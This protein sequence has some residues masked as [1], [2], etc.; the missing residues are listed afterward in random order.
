MNIFQYIFYHQNFYIKNLI[1][2]LLNLMLFYWYYVTAFCHVYS[3]TQISWILD[4]SLSI[5][6]A[7]LTY[8]VLCLGYSK[9]YR[10]SVD[11]NVK[12]LYRFVMFL[13]NFG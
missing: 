8:C 5:I 4:S 3:N 2:F 12:C 9:I 11:G 13:Y 6:F 1:Q 10:I 7:F